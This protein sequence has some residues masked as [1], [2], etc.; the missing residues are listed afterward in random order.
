M[1][2][3]GQDLQKA[4]AL[5]EY[6]D[7]VGDSFYDSL[8]DIFFRFAVVEKALTDY[9]IEARFMRRLW[10][11]S[12]KDG[13]SVALEVDGH[14][15]G[16]GALGWQVRLEDGTFLKPEQFTF[17]TVEHLSGVAILYS[18]ENSDFRKNLVRVAA[19]GASWLSSK[20][21]EFN[22]APAKK[23]TGPRFPRL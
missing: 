17:N 20:D 11:G 21:I 12:G 5:I 18:K 1:S 6:L 15:I 4:I 10:R 19:L 3:K 8:D 16:E 9:G 14:V 2:E 7:E 22:T 23:A 13:L